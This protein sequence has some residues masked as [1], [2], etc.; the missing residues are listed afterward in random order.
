MDADGRIKVWVSSSHYCSCG[1]SSRQPGDIHAPRF[2][3]EVAHDLAGDAC[4]ERGLSLIAL[5]ISGAKPVPALRGIRRL[6]LRRIGDEECSLLSQIVHPRAGSKVVGR[7]GAAVQHHHKGQRL[8]VIATRNIELVGATSRLIGKDVL[9]EL[10]A[11]GHSDG[12]AI[13]RGPSQP[14]K[15]TP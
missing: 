9:S 4:K 15:P 11:I 1:T 12:G 5:L 10:C 8:F 3:T 7:L 14:F 2:D 13:H 6:G